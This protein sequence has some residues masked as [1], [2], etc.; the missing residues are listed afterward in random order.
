MFLHVF[1][2]YISEPHPL[3]LALL[4]VGRNDRR[5]SEWLGELILNYK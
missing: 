2:S 4:G 3:V 5:F 1:L